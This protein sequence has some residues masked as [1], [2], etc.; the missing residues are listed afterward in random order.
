MKNIRNYLF[1]IL[2]I[3]ICLLISTFYKQANKSSIKNNKLQVTTSFYPLYFFAS[4][5]GGN[6]AEVQNI[7]PSGAEP[8]DYEPTAQD[9]ARI[10]K[11]NLLIL[12]GGKLEVWGDKIKDNIK[13]T[14]VV[15]VIAGNTIA[16]QQDPHVWLSPPL[17]KIEVKAIL[18]GFIQ[19]DPQNKSYYYENT[20]K[21]LS[22]LDEIDKEYKKGLINCN[23]KDIITSHAAFGY[24]SKAYGLNQVSIAGLSPDA[25]PSSKQLAEIAQFAKNHNVKYIFFE[26][27]VS[28]KLSETIANE[29]GA[30]TLVL[31]PI[32]GISGDDVKAGKNYLSIM[33]DNLKNLRIALECK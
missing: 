26:S 28:P 9:I 32:E 27:L 12:N 16:N 11:S 17:A 4:Q 5:I 29:V 33:K 1:L 20:N 25:E 3:I 22:Q 6:K 18:K 19:V 2:I 10:E 30:K 14:Q 15:T 24:L 13:G 8:H 7:T 23:Q 21:L 31:D